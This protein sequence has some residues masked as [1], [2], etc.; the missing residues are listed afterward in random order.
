MMSKA[1]A[2]EIT[3]ENVSQVIA[4]IDMLLGEERDK[5]WQEEKPMP[6]M[7]MSDELFE[8]LS[9]LAASAVWVEV[10]QKGHEYGDEI[11]GDNF[12]ALLDE[13]SRLRARE[14]ELEAAVIKMSYFGETE[15]AAIELHELADAVLREVN[16]RGDE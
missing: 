14:K 8:A 3:R 7:P 6:A 12:R 16:D 9:E 15:T 11:S 2:V 1:M 4:N 5:L 13:V 10:H